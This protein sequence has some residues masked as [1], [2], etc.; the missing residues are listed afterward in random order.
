MNLWQ[1]KSLGTIRT[2]AVRVSRLERFMSRNQLF[3]FFGGKNQH[4]NV[5]QM[6]V[7]DVLLMAEIPNNHLG[8]INT[9][10]F[11]DSLKYRSP[12][13]RRSLF[14]SAMHRSHGTCHIGFM[15]MM[16]HLWIHI[17]TSFLML[18]GSCCRLNG[19]NGMKWIVNQKKGLLPLGFLCHVIFGDDV[20]TY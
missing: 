4:V 9:L 15:N 18:I 1:H 11:H 10:Y 13:L 14:S 12:L 2:E 7:N 20:D 8:W 6:L 17:A 16:N 3:F 19:M 5:K